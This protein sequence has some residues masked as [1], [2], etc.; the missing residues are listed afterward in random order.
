MT[1]S[2]SKDFASYQDL[3]LLP[4][5]NPVRHANSSSLVKFPLDI[6]LVVQSWPLTRSE[7]PP[8]T[9]AKG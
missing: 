4:L 2:L 8:A 1:S 9:R 7:Q 3:N 5:V 6:F